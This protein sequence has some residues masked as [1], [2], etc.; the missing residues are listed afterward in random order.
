M[1]IVDYAMPLMK[2]EGLAKQA[3]ELCLKHRFEEA[4]EVALQIRTEARILGL[5]LAIM[6]NKD[7]VHRLHE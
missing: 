1:E 4:E 3:Y 5:T 7:E 2:I 6:Q